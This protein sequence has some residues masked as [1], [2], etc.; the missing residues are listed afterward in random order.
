MDKLF[1][2][3]MATLAVV[4]PVALGTVLAVV[5][6][7]AL[8]RPVLLRLGVRYAARRK[9]RTA[10][11][12]VGLMLGTAM[13]TAALNTGDAMTYTIRSAVLSG[14]GSIDEVVS[15]Q[16]ESDIEV[17]GEDAELRYIDEA[18]FPEVRDAFLATGLVDAV[19]PAIAETVGVQDVTTQQTEPRVYLTAINPEYG[20]EFVDARDV[21]GGKVTLSD[22]ATGD[23]YLNQDAADELDAKPGDRLAVFAGAEGREFQVRAI[24]TG[25][26]TS[27][28]V[29]A[30]IMRLDSAQALLGKEGQIRHIII[31]NNGDATSGARLT[32]AVIDGGQP[33]LD[34]LG[35]FIEPTKR[36]DLKEADDAGSAFTAFF[37]TF[38][39]FSVIAGMMLIFLIFVMLA[40]ERKS[41][42]GIARAV[43]TERRQLVE[44][45]M[46]EGMLYDLLAAA[47]GALLGI[48]VAY[49]MVL[50]MA[51]AVGVWG[52][53]IR[54][55]VQMRSI[56][57]AYCLGVLLTFIVVTVSAWKVSVLNIVTAIRNL[58]EPMVSRAKRGSLIL[59]VVLAVLGVL[60]AFAGVSGKQWT[61]LYLGVSLVI[62][63]LVPAMLWL[64]FPNRAAFTVPS[65]A[66]VVW[67]LLPSDV[68]DP[69]LPLMAV[70]FSSW[71]TGGVITVLGATWLV[72]YNS[73]LALGAIMAIF[74]RLTWLAPVLKTAVS[75]PLTNRFRT[76]MTLAMF[77]LVVFNLVVGAAT[78]NSF[79]Q[80]WND[81]TAFG[82]GYDIRATTVRV[83][84]IEDM[85]AAVAQSQTLD[86]SDFQV[87]AGQS[88]LGLDARQMNAEG[89]VAGAYA[90]RGLDDTFLETNEYGLGAIAEGYTSARQ[91][92]DAIRADPKL[93][94][95]DALP[96]PHRADFSLGAGK[97]DFV[98]TG[99]YA[100]DNGFAPVP[101]ELTDRATGKKTGVQIIGIMKDAAPFFMVGIL[102]NQKLME[103]EFPEQAAVVTHFIGLRE[104][105]DVEA[106][107]KALES[108]FLMNGMEAEVMQ[109]ELDKT[110]GT[111]QTFVYLLQ[112]FLG[113]GLI[114]GV[115]ALGVIS[116]RSV[117]ERRHE[118]GVMRSIGYERRMVQM[119]FLLE[120]SMVALV[121]LLLGTVLGI[122][123]SYNVIL[124]QSE[125][126][127][128]ENLRLAVPWRDLVIVYALVYGAALVTTFLPALQ[129]S[130]VYPAE[131]LRYQ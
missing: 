51:R 74:G 81:V 124:D 8:R 72:M 57:V 94:V 47:V 107:G 49:G 127:S 63:S 88:L 116:A 44:M 93:A 83:N 65:V 79:T 54:H 73:D 104:G 89:A 28:T 126:P 125:Q 102:T 131:A 103:Q 42:M 67:S 45:F 95:V 109:E 108:A 26:G 98:L 30:M 34:R 69:L 32:D 80:A 76:G 6:G 5:V 17:T 2:L 119:S 52:I 110:V 61:P 14:L 118:I 48:A 1:G 91:V 37:M 25:D 64:R 46:F 12:V 86:G 56:V 21:D 3:P 82:G 24:V 36:D 85:R 66:L 19:A 58:P 22:L 90:V 62:I 31:S 120:S 60:I 78:T 123:V 38:G 16:E 11:I 53:D 50:V 7:L 10:L 68:L 33:A 117:V 101:V 59:A 114:V 99:I 39:T 29:S 35:L 97:P 20:E 111:N 41:E 77:T 13:V 71:V 40:A 4:L 128:W 130:R 87:V 113:L 18:D 105:A 70:D 9:G 112:G 23:V 96:V 115:A 55:D 129:A 106:T 27:S 100:D 43:G 84:T 122:I 92:W 75:Y 15:S 121:S